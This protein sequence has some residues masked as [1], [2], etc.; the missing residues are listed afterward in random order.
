MHTLTGFKDHF[1]YTKTTQAGDHLRIEKVTI[2]GVEQFGFY[3]NNFMLDNDV[4]LDV[5][6]NIYNLELKEAS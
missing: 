4:D 3:V 5:L 2:N 6:L 1:V